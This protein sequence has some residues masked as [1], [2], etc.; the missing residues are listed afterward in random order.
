MWR[1]NPPFVK[2]K[3]CFRRQ[4]LLVGRI[5]IKVVNMNMAELSVEIPNET[6]S[7][8][9]VKTGIKRRRTVTSCLPCYSKKQKCDRQF[10]CDQ[11]SRRRRPEQCTYSTRVSP[12]VRSQPIETDKTTAQ[13]EQRPQIAT[14]DSFVNSAPLEGGRAKRPSILSEAFGYFDASGYNML[15][16]LHQLGYK[17]EISAREINPTVLS[18]LSTGVQEKLRRMPARVVVDFLV[19]YFFQEVNWIHQFVFAPMFMAKYK[20]WW[21]LEQFMLVEDVEFALLILHICIYTSYFI[22][23]K[24]YTSDTIR[25]QSLSDIRNHCGDIVDGLD[26]IC[27]PLACKASLTRIQHLCLAALTHEHEGRMRLSRS[28]FSGILQEVREAGMHREP[29]DPGAC[30]LDELEQEMRRRMFCNLYIWDMR[31]S[32]SLDYDPWLMETPFTINLPKM[33]LATNTGGTSSSGPDP[34]IGRVL[35]AQLAKFWTSRPKETSNDYNPSI[36]E[37]WYEKF[38]TDFLPRIPTPF[39]LCPNTEWD[40]QVPDLPRQRQLFHL[41]LYESICH[42]FRQLLKIKFTQVQSLPRY[43]ASLLKHHRRLLIAAAVAQLDST[44]VLHSMLGSEQ[45][46]FPL[47]PFHYFE[48]ALCL[49]LS[50]QIGDTHWNEDYQMNDEQATDCNTVPWF[51]SR[52]L[53][54]LNTDISK[55]QCLQ[56]IENTVRSLDN[57][58]IC[59]DAAETAACVLRRGVSC[60]REESIFR[61]AAAKKQVESPELGSTFLSVARGLDNEDSDKSGG[62][63]DYTYPSQPL[64]DGERV[65]IDHVVNSVMFTPQESIGRNTPG[66]NGIDGIDLDGLI[67]SSLLSNSLMLEEWNGYTELVE[68]EGDRNC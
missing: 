3:H 17:D 31:L 35:Q 11:C 29:I 37:E 9:A 47:I 50:L 14:I 28:A 66:I 18:D 53:L 6:R 41:S 22:P 15:G 30:G 61:T 12:L 25:G 2:N 26:E 19:Q 34:F 42:N 43:K 1:I 39:A 8:P 52:R 16:I 4:S 51:D 68:F 63:F 38:C 20:R 33:H 62:E 64:E 54:S 45:T 60:L 7:T 32:N 40:K 65:S 59:S 55:A 57:L 27:E 24:T 48:G 10:P 44:S 46:R 36:A 5:Q 58:S 67:D 13:Q 21:G 23:S 56:I 49:S